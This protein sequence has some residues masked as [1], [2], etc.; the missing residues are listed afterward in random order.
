MDKNIITAID[1]G[2]TK[3]CVIVARVIAGVECEILGVGKSLS[4]GLRK[5]V[6]VDIARTIQSIKHAIKKAEKMAEVSIEYA[7]IGV[8][9]AH[10]SS[11][12]SVGIVPIERGVIRLLDVRK[13]LEAA[14]AIAIPEGKQVLHVLPQRYVIDGNVVVDPIGMHGIRLEISAHIILGAVTSI[15]DLVSCCEYAGVQVQDVVLEQL[16]SS[17]SV[18]SSDE[19]YLGVGLLD[20]GGGTSD[21]AVH[22]K[23]SIA[24]TMVLPVAGNHF[25]Q[26][27]AIGLRIAIEQ[28]ELVKK[29]HGSITSSEDNY[30]IEVEMVHGRDLQ[31]V[32]QH[33]IVR[34]LKPRAKELLTFINQEIIERNL[35]PLLTTGIVLTGGGSL[36][37]DLELLGEEIFDCPVRIG[38]PKVTYDLLDSLENPMYAT[39]Y[40]LLLYTLEQSQMQV[41]NKIANSMQQR[42]VEKMKTWVVDFFS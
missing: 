15:A 38:A 30:P 16:A 3:I 7:C 13:A 18:L 9:G 34:V 25:T 28:A 22:Y 1:I 31:V 12:N 29:S 10:I 24:H 39:G 8:A 4:L 42:I 36:L 23:E 27:L 26:D 32:M 2:T 19:R 6:V 11:I 40:G 35:M 41:Q 20:I 33:D 14:R 5:G 37:N 21:F 17:A